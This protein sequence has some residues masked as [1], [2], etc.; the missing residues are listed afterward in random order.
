MNILKFQISGKNAFFRN[1]EVNDGDITYSFGHIHKVALLGILGAVLGMRGHNQSFYAEQA[2][3]IHPEFYTKLNNLKVA[4]QPNAEEGYF[5]RKKYNMVNTC[6]YSINKDTK[7]GQ[8]L[9]YTEQWLENPSWDIYIDLSSVD[10]YISDILLDYI[11]NNKCVY[12]PYLGK[13]NHIAIID[14]VEVFEGT[15]VENKNNI[16]IDSM[17]IYNKELTIHSPSIFDFDV[18][19]EYRE[20]LPVG[21][22]DTNCQYNKSLLI[23]TNKKCSFKDELILE[24]NNKNLIF[25]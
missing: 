22:L 2:D 25:I 6:G 10:K 20:L 24:V 5:Q 19:F 1:N 16:K 17:F 21:Y 8:T 9:M 14:N 12:I 13:T 18:F 11:S 4:I 7:K 3:Y 15:L 23:Y